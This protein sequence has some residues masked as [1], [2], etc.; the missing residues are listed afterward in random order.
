MH[1]LAKKAGILCYIFKTA[2]KLEFYGAFLC[3]RTACPCLDKKNLL[4]I[5]PSPRKR[6]P[7][8]QQHLLPVGAPGEGDGG[9]RRRLQDLQGK[10]PGG[11]VRNLSRNLQNWTRLANCTGLS[12]QATVNQLTSTTNRSTCERLILVSCNF[13]N[14]CDGQ[15]DWTDG[16]GGSYY[17]YSGH[18]GEFKVIFCFIV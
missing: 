18:M 12:V 17:S 2:L 1:G 3:T 13:R 8:I 4:F 16:L 9:Q 7:P 6:R 5:L 11:M 15:L 14:D 10:E